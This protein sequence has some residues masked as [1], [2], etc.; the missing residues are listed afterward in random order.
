MNDLKWYDWVPI[1]GLASAWK[2][3]MEDDKAYPFI[4]Y[5]FTFFF[6]PIIIAIIQK[7]IN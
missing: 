2:K 3:K 7:I 1:F 6:S 4:L 5:H